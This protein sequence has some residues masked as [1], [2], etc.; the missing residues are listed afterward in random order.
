MREVGHNGS[1]ARLG[2]WSTSSKAHE[3]AT[4]QQTAY[5]SSLVAID[6]DIAKVFIQKVS[7]W[8][9]SVM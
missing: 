9:A 5:M 2:L 7:L 8:C 1:Q 3:A 6:A 4:S